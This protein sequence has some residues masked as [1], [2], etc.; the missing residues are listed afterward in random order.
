MIKGQ[1][2]KNNLVAKESYYVDKQILS[3]FEDIDTSVKEDT[4]KQGNKWVNKGKEGTHGSFKTKKAADAQRKAMFASG[5]KE[6]VNEDINMTR[7]EMIDW[8][9]DNW[10]NNPDTADWLYDYLTELGFNIDDDSDEEEGF[11]ANLTDDNLRM[12][13]DEL[14]PNTKP[15]TKEQI[16]KIKDTLKSLG[17]ISNVDDIY[18]RSEVTFDLSM[19]DGDTFRIQIYKI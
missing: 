8:I 6:A 12:I 16:N 2:S 11:Y 7:Q 15:R 19:T 9:E 1:N 18:S 10:N 4:V 3:A 5:H 14:K 13:I 17:R